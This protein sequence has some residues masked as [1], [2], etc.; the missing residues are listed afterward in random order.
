MSRASAAWR[1]GCDRADAGAGGSWRVLLRLRCV[2]VLQAQMLQVVAH[3]LVP[4]LVGH[5][6]DGAVIGPRHQK[7]VAVT[8]RQRMLL[9]QVVDPF[10][11]FRNGAVEVVR[12]LL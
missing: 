2:G 12:I 4:S 1:T 7:D 11:E 8:R 3:L 9:L 5:G 6:H 10:L